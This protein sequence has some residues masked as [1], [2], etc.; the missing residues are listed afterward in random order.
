[1]I[2][3][4]LEEPDGTYGV[5]EGQTYLFA[6]KLRNGGWDHFVDALVWDSETAPHWHD[7]GH[8]WDGCESE[9]YFTKIQ[10]P[11]AETPVAT[12]TAEPSDAATAEAA[13]DAGY[14]VGRTDGYADAKNY[15]R[16]IDDKNPYRK[17][18]PHDYSNDPRLAY[19]LANPP[20]P[21][22]ARIIERKE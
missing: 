11:G 5:E 16:R 2:W 3:T 18:E 1:M 20:G 12:E 19:A 9:M 14:C 7:C 22:H 13:W 21:R 8:G 6:I 10:S 4:K 17:T 15:A